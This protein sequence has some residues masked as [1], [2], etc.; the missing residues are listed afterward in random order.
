MIIIERRLKRLKNG[1]IKVRKLEDPASL[2]R[3][4][5]RDF[6]EIFIAMLVIN[7]LFIAGSTALVTIM[8][9]FDGSIGVVHS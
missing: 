5:V 1:G 7:L 2:Y 4:P 3:G 8:L 9:Y 6:F